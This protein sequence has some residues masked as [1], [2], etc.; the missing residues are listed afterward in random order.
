MEIFIVIIIILLVY[1]IYIL[2]KKNST[3]T[4]KKVSSDFKNQHNNE[5]FIDDE[6][7]IK[8]EYIIDP[9][10]EEDRFLRSFMTKLKNERDFGHIMGPFRFKTTEEFDEE[11]NEEDTSVYSNEYDYGTQT[12][13]IPYK[14]HFLMISIPEG[15]FLDL[16]KT[17]K[18][19]V[20]DGKEDIKEKKFILNID[21]FKLEN[22]ST[23]WIGAVNINLETSKILVGYFEGKDIETLWQYF[24]DL[25]DNKSKIKLRS[26]EELF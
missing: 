19:L 25:L 24:E 26:L 1:I 15:N 16:R 14:K 18:N 23:K 8:N 20:I 13:V 11:S 7:N 12:N 6:G 9:S 22:L 3:N 10:N 17:L 4:T 21:A 5:S 2:K